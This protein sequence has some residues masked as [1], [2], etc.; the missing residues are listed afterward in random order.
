VNL[1]VCVFGHACVHIDLHTWHLCKGQRTT[2]ESMLSFHNVGPRDRT[3]II[4]EHLYPLSLP[5]FRLGNVFFKASIF[6]FLLKI[7]LY[8]I[9]SFIM[10]SS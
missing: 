2:L 8:K 6:F 1:C 4:C 5:L 3:Q 7:L 10:T 9:G